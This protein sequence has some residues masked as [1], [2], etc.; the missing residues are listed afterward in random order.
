MGALPTTLLGLVQPQLV[1]GVVG[2][3]EVD[4]VRTA[5]SGHAV[6]SHQVSLPVWQVKPSK[7]SGSLRLSTVLVA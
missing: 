7:S 4:L 6:V 3:D 1:P 5:S 2:D